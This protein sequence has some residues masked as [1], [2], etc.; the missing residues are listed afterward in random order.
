VLISP[1][2][3][4]GLQRLRVPN[5]LALALAASLG[6]QIAV[7]PLMAMLTGR[8]SPVSPLATLAVDPALLPLMIFGIL[9]GVS[10]AIFP[11][12]GWVFALPAGWCSAWMIWWA[13]FWA[14]LPFASIGL[15]SVHPAWALAYYGLLSYA[16]WAIGHRTKT[17]DSSSA[18]LLG[19][20]RLR[21]LT[22]VA[23][24]LWIVLLGMV[25]GR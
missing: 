6:A 8:I 23:L 9:A 5:L 18:V 24:A 20:A 22:G 3:A 15:D 16:L 17:A 12:A 4:G 25:I 1:H 7:L 13:Q 11:L 2:I 21:A 19:D 10:G 14:S